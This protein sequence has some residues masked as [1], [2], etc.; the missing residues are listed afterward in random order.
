MLRRTL[1]ALGLAA[2]VSIAAVSHADDVI[3]GAS[4]PL[5]GALASFGSFQRWGYE[6]ALAEAN[7]SGGVTIA[8]KRQTLR[9][10]VRDDKTDANISA[11]NVETLISRDHAVAL[12]GSCTP[13]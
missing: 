3:V 9:L 7:K 11:S 4:L 6:R 2:S 12:L 5:S 13:A 8:G 1:T 10:V